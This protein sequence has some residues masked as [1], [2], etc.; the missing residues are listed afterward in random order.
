MMERRNLLALGTFG[1]LGTGITGAI[2]GHSFLSMKN[3]PKGG[4]TEDDRIAYK[5]RDIRLSRGQDTI[6]LGEEIEFEITNTSDSRISLG[7]HNPWAIETYLDG[8]WRTVTWTGDDYYDL[9]ATLL[10]PGESRVETI[11]V[12]A[13]HLERRGDVRTELQ[14]GTYRFVLLGPSPFLA[15]A[16][17]CRRERS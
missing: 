6:H 12:A 8:G 15:V 16:R 1:L 17:Y 5:H 7:C 9:C 14:P 3:T 11:T 13:D 2:L 10:S 4:Y